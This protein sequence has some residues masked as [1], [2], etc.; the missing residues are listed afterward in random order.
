METLFSLAGDLPATPSLSGLAYLPDYVKPNE[1]SELVNAIDAAPWNT[2]WARRRQFYGKAYGRG[3]AVETP[4]P[5][6]ARFVVTRTHQDQRTERPF[7]QTLVNEY[8]AGQGI[9]L[10]RDHEPFA[11]TVASL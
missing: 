8:L 7:D 9:A 6:W 2:A 5:E 11:R 4:I 10:H 3:T 1:E